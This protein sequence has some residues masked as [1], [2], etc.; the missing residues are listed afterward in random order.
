MSNTLH[1]HVQNDDLLNLQTSIRSFSATALK[2]LLSE[3]DD[4]S[5]LRPLDLAIKLGRTPLVQ[6][7][8]D[9]GSD[10]SA[11]PNGFAVLDWATCCYLIDPTPV[12]RAVIDAL[13]PYAPYGLGWRSGYY[14]VRSDHNAPAPSLVAA[15]ARVLAFAQD[16]RQH[17]PQ[18][19]E[20]VEGHD[21]APALAQALNCFASVRDG[22]DPLPFRMAM[23]RVSCNHRTLSNDATVGIVPGLADIVLRLQNKPGALDLVLKLVEPSQPGACGNQPAQRAFMVMNAV[24]LCEALAN[25]NPDPHQ[26]IEA[27][28]SYAAA[29]LIVRRVAKRIT[30]INLANGESPLVGIGNRVEYFNRVGAAVGQRL[31]GRALPQ[32]VGLLP[33]EASVPLG[34]VVNPACGQNDHRSFVKDVARECADVLAGKRND[35]VRGV[36]CFAPEIDTF[37]QDVLLDRIDRADVLRARNN[38]IRDVLQRGARASVSHEYAFS[39]DLTEVHVWRNG[40]RVAGDS[41]VYKEAAHAVKIAYERRRGL[42]CD[43]LTSGYLNGLRDQSPDWN[44]DHGSPLGHFLATIA[45]RSGLSELLSPLAKAGV[46]LHATYADKSN[47]AAIAALH[48][49]REVIGVLHEL[50]V[51]VAAPLSTGSERWLT[52]AEIAAKHGH[53]AT[54]PQLEAIAAASSGH[55]VAGTPAVP[56]PG[57]VASRRPVS[58]NTR[59]AAPRAALPL[60]SRRYS[61][62]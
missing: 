50:G 19:W 52:P 44:A 25:D 39:D 59:P 55:R 27:S 43:R 5:H 8:V 46:N 49:H 54:D 32:L 23:L 14:D 33:D 15:S 4:T 18:A 47:L 7:L 9:A 58:T 11:L 26:A 34:G 36:L 31:R 3:R 21:G 57:S 60:P 10:L 1:E 37:W 29:H 35:L 13:G 40:E 2:T 41:N 56:A 38:P 12:R 16:G 42:L 17:N 53:T 61:Y 45:A 51:N 28:R 48:G 30:D 24:P 20:R 62:P 22:E 6:A